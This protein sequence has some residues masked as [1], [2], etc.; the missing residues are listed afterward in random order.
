MSE[1]FRNIK[2]NGKCVMDG[3]IEEIKYLNTTELFLWEIE[4]KMRTWLFMIC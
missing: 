3:K 2:S 4:F 1:I